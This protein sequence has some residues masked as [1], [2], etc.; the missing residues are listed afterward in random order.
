MHVHGYQKNNRFYNAIEMS[1]ELTEK[2][3]SLVLDN[4]LETRL[5]IFSCHNE[6]TLF[7]F[8]AAG[9][10]TELHYASFFPCRLLRHHEVFLRKLYVQVPGRFFE[11]DET[12]SYKI[13]VR[14]FSSRNLHYNWNDPVEKP[15]GDGFSFVFENAVYRLASIRCIFCL[16][17]QASEESLC[18]HIENVHMYFKAVLCEAAHAKEEDSSQCEVS[19]H[20]PVRSSASIF[21][22][23]KNAQSVSATRRMIKIIPVNG[24][25]LQNVQGIF[26]FYRRQRRIDRSRIYT[27][28]YTNYLEPETF[29]PL[30]TKK[31]SFPWQKWL[32]GKRLDEII[33][34]PAEQV[35]IIKEWNIF[36]QGKKVSPSSRNI[37]CYVK[38]FVKMHNPSFE[39]FMFITCLYN[40][41]V[42]SIEEVCEVIME[43]VL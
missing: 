32:M 26:C 11:I 15:T 23:T 16:K 18:Q 1:A 42:L 35:R 17:E 13:D 20:V 4:P 29:E 8:L 33:D 14:V 41:A 27:F 7:V 39:M 9:R 24:N 25:A 3:N 28:P 12:P 22:K 40:N 31:I 21:Y 10:C 2:N 38:E 19:G 5:G 6:I 34:L 37:L 43:K 30:G 36:I